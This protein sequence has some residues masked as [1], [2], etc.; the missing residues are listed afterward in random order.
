MPGVLLSQP[1]Q[2]VMDRVQWVPDET[3]ALAVPAKILIIHM[4]QKPGNHF[5]QH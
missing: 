2:Q 3:P 5:H 1:V 4:S